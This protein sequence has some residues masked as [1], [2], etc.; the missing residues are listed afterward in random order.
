ML[1]ANVDY[2]YDPLIGDRR[3]L[4]GASAVAAYSANDVWRFTAEVGTAMNPDPAQ[5]SWLTVA[6]FGA[7]ATV[8]KGI[9]VDAGYQVRLTRNAP[10]RNHPRRRDAPLVTPGGS[11]RMMT[12][13]KAGER[14]PC[15]P[16]LARFVAQLLVRRL[17]RSRAHGLRA[18]ARDQ[19]GSRAAGDGL[20]HAR[21]SRHGDHQLC[22]RR[23]ARAQRQHGQRLGDRPGRRAADERRTRRAAQ[24][25]QSVEDRARA[26]PA[27]LDRAG[28]L[29]HRP[30]YEQTH[31][32]AAAKRGRLRLI[33]SPDGR[34]GSVTIHQDATV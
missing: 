8:V 13:R 27:D 1:A 16:R 22:A 14:G 26:F 4:W 3:D 31:V 20:R 23:R 5:T 33:A 2:V 9:D 21:P 11:I 29:R 15:R 30:G 7:I 18:A 34:D 17:P 24:R 6:R 10:V 32:P 19:R 25:V 12:L 28:A